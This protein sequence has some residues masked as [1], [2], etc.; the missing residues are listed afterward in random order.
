MT[1]IRSC[2]VVVTSAVGALAIAAAAFGGEPTAGRIVGG[3]ST[4]AVAAGESW[5]SVGARFGEDPEVI[6][7]E[8]ALRADKPL[9]AGQ[10]LRID[11]RHIVPDVSSPRSI[12]VNLP[13]RMLFFADDA[14]HVTGL[15]VA[16]G[17]STWRTPIAT[18]EIRTMERDPSWEVP[19]SIQ[20]EARHAGRS[21]PA[22]VPPG[23]DNPLGKFWLGLTI[24]NVGIHGTNAPLSIYRL[25]THGCMRLHPDDI[26]WLFDRVEI[27]WPGEIIYEPVLLAVVGSDVFIEAHPDVYGRAAGDEREWVRDR[28]AAL[29]VTGR[30]DWTLVD[31]ELRRRSGIARL[32]SSPSRDD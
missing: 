29:G 31:R 32:V 22:V 15:P 11:N 12:V 23:P 18:F 9:R 14:N 6:A 4:H 17:R 21:L 24:P 30:I 25:A 27:G 28:A 10:V 13:Q 3:T 26:E 20:E 16:A 8:N 1:T 5:R 2:R 19:V 7:A